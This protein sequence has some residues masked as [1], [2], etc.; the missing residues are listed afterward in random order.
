MVF[1]WYTL[2]G[3]L[4]TAVHYAV[5]LVLVE[6]FGMPPSPSAVAGAL[7]GAAVSYIVNRLITFPG[8]TVRHQLAVPRF[9]AVAVA[10]ALV[11]GALVWAGVHWLGWHYLLA[12]A[13]ATLLV[14]G[15]TYRL[16]RSWTFA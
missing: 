16:N 15:L 10:G 8:A 11:N 1:F 2:A 14:L 9:L 3:G 5:L 12:Q 13:V 7:C 4:A 6:L